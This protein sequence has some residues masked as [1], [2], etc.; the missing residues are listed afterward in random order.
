MTRQVLAR[1]L[2]VFTAFFGWNSSARGEVLWDNF[3]DSF[4]VDPIDGYDVVGP[5]SPDMLETRQAM[6]FLVTGGD[7]YL[8]SVEVPLVGTD[9]V[10]VHTVRVAVYS[11]VA[12]IPGTELDAVNVSVGSDPELVTAYYLGA[13]VL[14]EGRQYWAVVGGV[15]AAEVR[16][17][18]PDPPLTGTR[19]TRIARGPGLPLG[20]WQLDTNADES[21]FRV[22]G[23]TEPGLCV[24]VVCMPSDQCHVAGA[25]D[26]VTGLC[27]D[28]SEPDGTSCD[29]GN[30]DTID[31]QCVMGV[32]DSLNPCAGV[33]CSDHGFCDDSTGLCSC[34]DGWTGDDCAVLLDSDGDGLPDL[35]DVCPDEDASGFDADGDGCIDTFDGLADL[36]I[37]LPN[38]SVAA[39]IKRSLVAKLAAAERRLAKNGICAA[40]HSLEALQREIRAQR[41]HKI[42]AET[43]DMLLDYI[44]NL[45]AQLLLDLPSQQ[46]CGAKRKQA[47]HRTR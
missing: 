1:V 16:W 46:R 32:C 4:A 30:P 18:D 7:F 29:D 6:P 8:A 20:F 36:I 37:D 41:G 15:G 25:C 39:E 23:A 33:D 27:T 40:I 44:E 13:T 24:G 14:L 31:D 28:P 38:E 12:G 22:H 10:S 47:G 2:V 19:A 35:D 3:G 5:H 43:A 17:L 9:S 34:D 42:D 11:T 26:P 45:I 21:A